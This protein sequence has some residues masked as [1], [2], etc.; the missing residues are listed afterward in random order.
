MIYYPLKGLALLLNLVLSDCQIKEN[1]AIPKLIYS[2]TGCQKPGHQIRAV[3]FS[4]KL[5]ADSLMI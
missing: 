2:V 1:S 4:G 5:M 3:T